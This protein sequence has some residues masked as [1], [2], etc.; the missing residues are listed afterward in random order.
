MDGIILTAEH[1]LKS[2]DEGFVIED[3]RTGKVIQQINASHDNKYH[4]QYPIKGTPDGRYI[5]TQKGNS[6]SKN[7][8]L[9]MWDIHTGNFVRTFDNCKGR[10]KSID[11]TADGQY[12]VVLAYDYPSRII[13]VLDIQT[14]ELTLSI[15]PNE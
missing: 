13:K 11:I 2:T 9:A 6:E 1:G 14:G 7:Q 8:I 5:L 12:A 10:I 3:F 4:R 15:N